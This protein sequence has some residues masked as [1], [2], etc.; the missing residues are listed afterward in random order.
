VGRGGSRLSLKKRLYRI[1]RR[2]ASEVLYLPFKPTN[3][4]KKWSAKKIEKELRILGDDIKIYKTLL[5]IHYP[6]THVFRELGK[7]RVR[8]KRRAG[9]LWD[10]L[11]DEV[12]SFVDSI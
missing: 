7:L 10:L 11:S 6:S 5:N 9:D 1:E 3:K 8:I 12:K 4:W 2:K